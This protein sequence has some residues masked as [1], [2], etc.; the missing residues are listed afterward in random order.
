MQKMTVLS[1]FYI[2]EQITACSADPTETTPCSANT[3]GKDL[4]E[5]GMCVG[6]QIF[7]PEKNCSWQFTNIEL[8]QFHIL[9]VSATQCPEA[10]PNACMDNANG[11]TVCHNGDCVGKQF[12][13]S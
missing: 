5:N 8:I 4:C 11:K 3:N 1:N 12:F 10:T 9:S 13:T 6:K 7:C 2:S